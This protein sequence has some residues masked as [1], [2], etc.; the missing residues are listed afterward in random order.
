MTDGLNEVKPITREMMGF[1]K[2]NASY[3]LAAGSRFE[4]GLKPA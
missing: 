1:A 2:L 3:A 4:A